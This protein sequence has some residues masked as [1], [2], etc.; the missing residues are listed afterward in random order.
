MEK[1]PKGNNNEAPTEPLTDSEAPTVPL[2]GSEAPTVPLTGSEAPAVPHGENQGEIKESA[3]TTEQ[4]QKAGEAAHAV[5]NAL[6]GAKRLYNNQDSEP[7]AKTVAE[8]PVED[9]PNFDSISDQKA[10]GGK[11]LF[12]EQE[13]EPA[14][15]TI[16]ELPAEDK[17][18]FDS[19]SDQQAGGG[20]RLFNEGAKR[21]YNDQE[22]MDI[23]GDKMKAPLPEE[24]P[25][26]ITDERIHNPYE[27]EARAVAENEAR[28]HPDFHN[29]DNIKDKDERFA[30]QLERARVVAKAGDEA[31]RKFREE[32]QA[33]R[34]QIVRDFNDGKEETPEQ[35]EYREKFEA[36]RKRDD[37]ILQEELQAALADKENNNDDDDGRSI[38]KEDANNL[39]A[40]ARYEARQKEIDQEIK[41]EARKQAQMEIQRPVG[42]YKDRDDNF[43]SELRYQKEVNENAKEKEEK[44]RD[45]KMRKGI[46][47]KISSGSELTK[48]EQEYLAQ[49]FVEYAQKQERIKKLE[50]ERKR[51]QEEIAE[52]QRAIKAIND[53]I[54]KETE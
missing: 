1:Q 31:Q 17:P 13:S 26:K 33:K 43:A 5:Q 10:G 35:R 49:F 51:L 30:R 54:K 28:N 44:L 41:A 40:Q 8:L 48:E 12:N 32:D 20:K 29:V 7:V 2:T 18:N 39:V 27:A 9:K 45:E 50:E 4:S 47:E 46:L 37:E 53:Q 22:G 42:A 21:L 24:A 3:A 19:V 36:W 52:R 25:A 34:E 14:G 38:T 23:N 15:K 11:R 6:E 16:A